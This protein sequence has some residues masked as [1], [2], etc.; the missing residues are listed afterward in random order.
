[1][2]ADSK[3]GCCLIELTLFHPV[4]KKEMKGIEK[5]AERY[6]E[7]LGKRIIIETVTA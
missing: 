2:E 4:N 5:A 6:G 3:K 1:M 7:Y